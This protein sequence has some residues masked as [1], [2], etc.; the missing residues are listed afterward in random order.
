MPSTCPAESKWRY[1]RPENMVPLCRKCIGILGW[2]SRPKLR[3]RLAA[4][5]WR[6]RFL[7]FQHWHE[8]FTQ[9]SLP[10]NW[11]RLEYPLWPEDYG[12]E[13]WEEGSSAAVFSYPQPPSEANIEALSAF[14]R[15]HYPVGRGRK[16]KKTNHFYNLGVN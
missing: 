3:Q 15:T 13:S 2:Q 16:K 6:E 4:I 7:A 11:D 5:L 14:I 12:G 9:S 8:A 1:G 10:A